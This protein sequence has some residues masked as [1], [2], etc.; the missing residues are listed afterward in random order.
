[1][2]NNPITIFPPQELRFYIESIVIETTQPK[3]DTGSFAV[4]PSPHIVLGFQY[5][6]QLKQIDEHGYKILNQ[7]GISGLQTDCRVFQGSCETRSILVKFHPWGAAAFLQAPLHLFTNQAF[8]LDEV[9]DPNDISTLEEQLVLAKTYDELSER[10][11]HFLKKQIEAHRPKQDLLKS[12]HI[13]S[14]IQQNSGSKTIKDLVTYS[15]FSERTLERYFKEWVGLT[16][17]K[18]SALT[19]FNEAWILLKQGHSV[20]EI[21]TQLNFYDQSHFI[22]DFKSFTGKTPT[23]W[24]LSDFSN[25]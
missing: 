10:I 20:E 12:K 5:R 11:I 16:P 21:L 8:S 22:N 24:Q 1:M 7:S 4:L 13:I 17:K 18:F 25:T 19:R 14:F 15:G 2:A 6:G 3:E 9:I 23:Q